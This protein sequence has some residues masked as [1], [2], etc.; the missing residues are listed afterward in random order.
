MTAT[1]AGRT[2]CTQLYAACGLSHGAPPPVLGRVA[3]FVSF[4]RGCSPVSTAL[5]GKGHAWCSREATAVGRLRAHWHRREA[6]VGRGQRLPPARSLGAVRTYEHQLRRSRGAVGNHEQ[7]RPELADKTRRARET[8]VQQHR[9]HAAC[10]GK[11]ILSFQLHPVW[12]IVAF[13]RV[14]SVHLIEG[15]VSRQ[16][17]ASGACPL[18]GEKVA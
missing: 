11:P 4:D 15:A 17:L 14:W 13:C 16:G 10:A 18:I 12:L 3:S 8:S 6:G 1:A 7:L 5:G 2:S 9:H